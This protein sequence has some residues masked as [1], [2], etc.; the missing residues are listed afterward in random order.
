MI[1]YILT[2]CTCNFVL[3]FRILLL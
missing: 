3:F 1:T 2:P